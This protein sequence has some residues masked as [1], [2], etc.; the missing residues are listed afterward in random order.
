MAKR[1]TFAEKIAEMPAEEIARWKTEEVEKNLKKLRTSYSRRVASFHKKG[2]VSQAELQYNVSNLPTKKIEDMTRNQMLL[3]VSKI[4][5]FF[6]AKTSTEKGIREVNR[7]QDIAIFGANKK[8]NPRYSMTNEERT[9]YWSLYTE[10]NNMYKT[11]SSKYGSESI[12]QM[13]GEIML[14]NDMNHDDFVAV[15]DEVQSRLKSEYDRTLE[16]EFVPNVFGGRGNG[17]RR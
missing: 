12:Q 3:E 10:F 8:G 11:D 2:L 14:K 6:E 17:F 4:K 1:K 15:L 7:Q 5:S 16:K 9:R 13:L